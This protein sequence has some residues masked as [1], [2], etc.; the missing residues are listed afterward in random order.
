M[1][2]KELISMLVS[3]VDSKSDCF[4]IPHTPKYMNVRNTIDFQIHEFMWFMIRSEASH[5]L[6]Q[7]GVSFHVR[8]FNSMSLINQYLCA[9][10]ILCFFKIRRG[11]FVWFTSAIYKTTHKYGTFLQ[12]LRPLISV[13]WN[14]V[15]LQLRGME[16]PQCCAFQIPS[17]KNDVGR[18]KKHLRHVRWKGRRES[19]RRSKVYEEEST[20]VSFWDFLGDR[21]ILGASYRCPQVSW[22]YQNHC[23][24]WCSGE[25]KKYLGWDAITMLIQ[26]DDA[27]TWVKSRYFQLFWSPASRKIDT[28]RHFCTSCVCRTSFVVENLNILWF[29][30]T[31]TF[32]KYLN[33]PRQ[34]SVLCVIP[35]K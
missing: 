18:F 10:W 28:L 12:A 35:R 3:A 24:E 33:L 5:E 30:H 2:C 14:A 6:L 31:K 22:K 23:R 9:H 29:Y 34:N 11:M 20:V 21:W 26:R 32:C 17:W 7:H 16:V 25:S 15:D 1:F 19:G 8:V 13:S 4:Y 27:M